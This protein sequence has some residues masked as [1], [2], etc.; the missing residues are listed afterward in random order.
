MTD[1]IKAAVE[2][3]QKANVELVVAV[4]RLDEAAKSHEIAKAAWGAANDALSEAEDDLM[5]KIALSVRSA[6]SPS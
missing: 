3:V 2:R 6:G 4:G 1:E 5:K